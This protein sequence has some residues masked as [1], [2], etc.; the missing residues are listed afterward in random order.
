MPAF[1]RDGARP[2]KFSP[3]SAAGPKRW[4]NSS[5]EC[6]VGMW[7]QNEDPAA[8]YDIQVQQTATIDDAD[9]SLVR[10]RFRVCLVGELKIFW[11]HIECVG[12]MSGGVFGY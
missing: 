3:C 1:A 7:G 4:F 12:R 9:I 11:C 6:T 8:F 2:L 10:T 5:A